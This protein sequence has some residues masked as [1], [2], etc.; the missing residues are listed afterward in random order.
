M[1]FETIERVGPAKPTLVPASGVRVSSR[2]A[3]AHGKAS[4]YLVV[5]IGAG[6]AQEM[7]LRGEETKLNLQFG[8][9][10]DAGMIGMSVDVTAGQ[11]IAKKSKSGFW[12]T[13][14]NG[15]SAEGLFALDVPEFT[16]SPVRVLFEQGKCPMA[17]FKASD[18]ML[19]VED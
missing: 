16:V 5:Q 1:P 19:A 6:L 8:T 18:E 13:T 3:A 17:V 10:K 11:F 7:V 12:K 4:R 15:A 9:G 2:A 14:I